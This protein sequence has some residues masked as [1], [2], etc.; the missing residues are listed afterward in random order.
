R[1]TRAGGPT[2]P[3]V[4]ALGN[5]VGNLTLAQQL[6]TARIAVAF[7]GNQSIGPGPRSSP[8]SWSWDTNA[9]QHRLQLRAVI[10]L[11]RRDH[12]RKRSSF[13]VA[14]QMKLGSQPTPTASEPFINRVLDPL[15]TSAWLGRRRAPLAC[16]WARGSGAV[17]IDLP[18]DRAHRIRAGLRISQNPVSGSIASPAVEP[19]CAGLP[20]PIPFGQITPRRARAQLPQD[21]IDHRPVVAPLPAA[22]HSAVAAAQ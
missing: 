19:V 14:S 13:P 10:A 12:D 15:F 8:P 16:W 2:C 18:N 22:P 4:A 3:L 20:R 9:S 21:P 17:Y 6:P 1:A 5:G 7:V 11:P